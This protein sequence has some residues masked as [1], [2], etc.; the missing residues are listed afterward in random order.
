[1]FQLRCFLAVAQELNFRR[2]AVR[3]NMTQPPLSRQIK[4]LEESLGLTLFDRDQR[5]VRLTPAG[6]SFRASA[7]DLLA[8]ADHAVQAARQAARGEVGSVSLGFVPSASLDFVPRIVTGLKRDMP[9]ITFDPIEMMSFEIIEALLSGRIDLGLTRTPGRQTEIE[10]LRIVRE[11]FVLAVP[12]GHALETAAMVRLE[13]L[14]GMPF[15]GYSLDRGGF[16]RDMQRA[17]FAAVGIVPDTVQE[18]SQTHTVLALV[19]SGL[20][21]ALIPRS[22]TA[23]QMETLRYRTVEIPDQFCSTLYLNIAPHRAT[24]LTARVRDCILAELRDD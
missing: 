12:A 10:S 5:S 8:R 6:T 18:V 13:D 24:I 16:L 7:T 3:M 20:G 15:V 17:L 21:V 11:P 1:M 4:L 22:A 14:D 9:D 19:N 23:M 2:A